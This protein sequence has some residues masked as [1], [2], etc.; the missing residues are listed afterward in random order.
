[1]RERMFD[2]KAQPEEIPCLATAM[3]YTPRY[4]EAE[5]HV[6]QHLPHDM[7]VLNLDRTTNGTVTRSLAFEMRTHTYAIIFIPNMPVIR[8]YFVHQTLLLH[9]VISK[10]WKQTP[11]HHM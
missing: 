8:T 5:R 7:T 10:I 9:A 1:M 11:K 3:A 2:L 4:L 6:R